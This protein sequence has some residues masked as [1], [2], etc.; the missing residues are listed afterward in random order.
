[1]IDK[2]LLSFQKATEKTFDKIQYLH[3]KNFQQPWLGANV[4]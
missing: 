3:D 4:P 1:M 2:I